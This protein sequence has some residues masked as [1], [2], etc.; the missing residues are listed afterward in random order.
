MGLPSAP[1]KS[2]SSAAAGAVSRPSKASTAAVVVQQEGAAAYAAGLRLDQREHHLHGDRRIHRRAA[3]LEDLVAGIGGQRVGR[4]HGE[5]FR[6]PA[7]LGREARSAFGLRGRAARGF[8]GG[9]L[10]S[11]VGR[12][13]GAGGQQRGGCQCR[14]GVSHGCLLEHR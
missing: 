11:E 8:A 3:G 5:F 13:A 9:H 1:R 10:V 2:F 7:R 14:E 12:V 4:G 6:G